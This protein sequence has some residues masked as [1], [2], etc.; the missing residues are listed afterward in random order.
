MK[1]ASIL[2]DPPWRFGNT[3]SRASAENHYP[4]MPTRQLIRMPVEDWAANDAVLW[5]WTTDAHLPDALQVM[6]AWGFA[7]KQTVTWVKQK[8]GG[9]LQIGL[10]NYLRHCHELLLLGTRGKP[11]RLRADLPSVIIAPRGE[12]SAK[13]IQMHS[14]AMA[15]SAGPYLEIFAR[16]Q[17]QGWHAAGNEVNWQQEGNQNVVTSI[18]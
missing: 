2:A 17:V 4:T 15:F 6:A 1:F 18:E 8:Q 3:A 5:L 7:Y 16:R 11:V 14:L 10:G 9:P 12:H 13:P